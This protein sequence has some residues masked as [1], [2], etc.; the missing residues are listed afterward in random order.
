MCSLM[1]YKIKKDEVNTTNKNIDERWLYSY[2]D[3][4]IEDWD[5]ATKVSDDEIKEIIK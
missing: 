5:Y 4:D 3:T 2:G 1:D